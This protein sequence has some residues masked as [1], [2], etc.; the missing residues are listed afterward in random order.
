MRAAETLQKCLRDGLDSMQI[1]KSKIRSTLVA[2][3]MLLMVIGAM[4]KL[5]GRF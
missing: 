5:F 2:L 3:G 1:D 4:M